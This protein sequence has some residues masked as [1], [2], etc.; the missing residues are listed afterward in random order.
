MTVDLDVCSLTVAFGPDPILSRITSRT[1]A[2]SRP[3]ICM[4][5][6]RTATRSRCMC[7]PVWPLPSLRWPTG[8]RNQD[9]PWKLTSEFSFQ[10]DTNMPATIS[11]DFV[12]GDQDESANVHTIDVAPMN[13]ESVGSHIVVTLQGMNGTTWTPV[14]TRQRRS[15]PRG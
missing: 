5:A 2:H 7:S 10:C 13:K 8:A 6:I 12:F 4:A 9:K 1:G 11:T 15:F 14:T 3:S